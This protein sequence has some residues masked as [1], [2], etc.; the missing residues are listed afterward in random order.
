MSVWQRLSN[1]QSEPEFSGVPPVRRIKSYPAQ[2][3]YVYQYYFDGLRDYDGCR[4]YR[5]QAA[6]DAKSFTPIVVGLPEEIVLAWEASA[7]RELIA[8][9]LYGVG[10]LLLFRHMDEIDPKALPGSSIKLTPDELE[11]ISEEL[12]L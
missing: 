1:R 2:S 7:G 6:I 5:F 8:T 4:E 9:E 10:K 11:R 3:G 12:D